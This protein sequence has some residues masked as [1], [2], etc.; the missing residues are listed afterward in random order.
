MPSEPVT[1]P[2]QSPQSTIAPSPP[3]APPDF[4]AL[5]DAH[6]PYVW[7]TLRRLGVREADLPDVSH[8]VFIVVARRIAD[9]DPARPMKPWLFGIAYRTAKDHRRLVRHARELPI[10][11]DLDP[12]DPAPLADELLDKAEQQALVRR[13]LATIDEDQRAVF[14]LFELDGATMPDVVEA[15]GVPLNT[16]YS[17]LRL[18]RAAFR[19]AVNRLSKKAER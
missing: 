1:E 14:V 17:R 5:F 11:D 15:L 3:A 19:V 18:A 7:K 12:S 6:F 2:L 4:R 13:A 16:A 8:D 9:F 10:A